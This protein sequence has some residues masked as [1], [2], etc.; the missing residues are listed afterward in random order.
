MSD[1]TAAFAVLAEPDSAPVSLTRAPNVPAGSPGSP[2]WLLEGRYRVVDRI[3]SG[4]MADVFRAHDELLGRDVAAKVFRA[5]PDGPDSSAGTNRPN[6]EL[7]ALARLN[8]PNLVV[9]FDGSIDATEGPAYLVMELINGP[10]LAKEILDGPLPEPQ[11]RELGIQIAD[12]LAYV[13]AMGM[14]HRDVKPANILLGTD[15]TTD[16]TT[17]RARLS[18]FGI[19]RLLGTER[20]TGVDLTLGTASYLAPEQARGL[21]VG[22][23]ADVYSLGLVLIEALTGVRA[24]DGPVMETVTARLLRSPDVPG[25]LPLPWPEL[26]TAMTDTNSS[27][28]PTAAQVAQT[29]RATRSHA[30]MPIGVAGAAA[31]AVGFVGPRIAVAPSAGP[32]MQP[33]RRRTGLRVATLLVG[34][35]LAGVVVLLLGPATHGQSSDQ[36][37][38]TT[39]S[40]T[41]PIKA[42]TSRPAPILP[43][44]T[45]NTGEQVTAPTT[46]VA[47]PVTAP[48][49]RAAHPTGSS[50]P[51]RTTPTQAVPTPSTPAVSAS[52]T[53]PVSSGS[54]AGSAGAATTVINPPPST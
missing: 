35:A 51:P 41:D 5:M 54:P 8:H 27:A 24:Y 43:V 52:P 42:T 46:Q 47:H 7:H 23:A 22:P 36:H 19:V 14:V 44:G 49:R 9:L 16:D 37:R 40:R 13:H 53:P 33:R 1:D 21:D 15:A 32:G 26:L 28:R 45:V 48:I 3:G 12:A 10:T 50:A 34:A 31:P 29:L 11:A 39:P 30:A 25:N 17:V 2:G 20:L 6:T 18:D 4:G 38:V